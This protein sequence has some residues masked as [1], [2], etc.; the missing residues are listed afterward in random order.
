MECA[1][2]AERIND[3]EYS[4][5]CNHTFHTKCII[6]WF[7]YCGTCPMCRSVPKFKTSDVLVRSKILRKVAFQKDAPRGLVKL[8]ERIKK[9]ENKVKE[10]KNAQTTHRNL[11][12]EIFKSQNKL[13][14]KLT[15]ARMKEHKL[16]RELG[17]YTDDRLKLPILVEKSRDI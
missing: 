8:V 13:H 12:K 15:N 11:H 9:I 7:R 14:E 17:M 1:I 4:L 5:E 6:D 3:N 2:C 10:L 16:K